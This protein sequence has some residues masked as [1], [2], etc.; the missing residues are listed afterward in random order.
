MEATRKLFVLISLTHIVLNLHPGLVSSNVTGERESM[1]NDSF[2]DNQS[3]EI[4]GNQPNSPK[5]YKV[6][7]QNGKGIKQLKMLTKDKDMMPV[8]KEGATF[9]DLKTSDD[10][11]SHRGGV[12]T[13]INDCHHH[14]GECGSRDD[15]IETSIYINLG[16]SS[17][18]K[19][20]FKCPPCLCT[21]THSNHIQAHCMGKHLK[22]I[23]STLPKNITYL[24]MSRNP[25]S[26]LNISEISEYTDLLSF[27]LNG[28][29]ALVQVSNDS[30]P[31]AGS[32]LQQL[33]LGRNKISEV[34]DTS[35]QFLSSLIYL[36]LSKNSLQRINN[37][38]FQGLVNLR[39]LDLSRNA[40]FHIDVGAFDCLTKLEQ[41]DL[42]HNTRFSYSIHHMPSR[43]FMPFQELRILYIQGNSNGFMQYPNAALATLKNLQKLVI[44]GLHSPANFGP[45][46]RSLRSFRALEFGTH[47]G[48]CYLVNITET[49]FE[50]IPYLN[51]LAL[52]KC[53]LKEVDRNFYKKIPHL[54]TLRIDNGE[55]TYTLFQA[56]E[57][58]EGLQNSSLKSLSFNRLY[59]T[60]LSC[61][62]LKAEQ[63]RYLQN[64]PLEELDLSFNYITFLQYDFNEKLP[65]SLKRLL[66]RNNAFGTKYA[67]LFGLLFLTELIELD[68][69]NQNVDQ[70][71]NKFIYYKSDM[72]HSCINQQD[73]KELK[74]YHSLHINDPNISSLAVRP[75]GNANVT[76]ST[77]KNTVKKQFGTMKGHLRLP[78]K[79]KII[80]ATRY[81]DFGLDL[82]ARRITTKHSLQ[83]IDLS[84]SFMAK[85]GYGHILN[86]IVKADL[87]QNYCK[88]I[89]SHFFR[90]NKSLRSLNL[91]NNFLGPS[92]AEDEN[93]IIFHQLKFVNSL[94]ISTN[95][96]YHL[97]DKFLTGLVQLVYIHLSDNKLRALTI[98]FANNRHIRFINAT[99][100]SISWIGRQT[101]DNLD[102]IARTHPVALDL[103][104]NPLPCTC[105]GLEILKWL[106]TTKV[107]IL[108][109]DFL[110]CTTRAAHAEDIGNL[111]LRINELQRQCRSTTLAVVL[112]SVIVAV[113]ITFIG[114]SLIYRYRW[115][116]IY[117]RNVALTRLFRNHNANEPCDFAYDA[118][119]VHTETAHNFVLGE[120]RQEL[121]R[122]R[123]HKLC[124]PEVDFMPGSLLVTDILAAAT[125]S[126][127]TVVICTPDIMQDNW[128]EYSI[129][130]ALNVEHFRK[131]KA[132]FLIL[133]EQETLQESHNQDQYRNQREEDPLLDHDCA[134]DKDLLLIK[135]RGDFIE[136]P[137]PGD[138]GVTEAVRKNFWD[139]ISEKLGHT[140][141]LNQP[142][143]VDD[144]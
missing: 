134:L 14:V 43:L 36:N 25:I 121:K 114:L 9:S 101:R 102:D 28:E 53:H 48:K 8:G 11:V 133:I 67:L 87:S 31:Q 10:K 94:D 4:Y 122:Q 128:A 77:P 55:T 40:I 27:E 63:A 17:F 127:T 66:L 51:Y 88:Y 12:K 34:E 90:F 136:Y 76:Y 24:D 123:G 91:S 96:I 46:L 5:A 137:L 125:N 18:K 132:L 64:I 100:N 80:R 74:K 104:Y 130:M 131:R 85:W 120:L 60:R 111:E 19:N 42:S 37:M 119:I 135:Q 22:S 35:F 50:N 15:G 117:L 108:N 138:H 116:L 62:V 58:L 69:S 126:M 39:T 75:H 13:P 20:D 6:M 68:V 45:E 83:E 23:P 82:F 21:V 52:E 129:K 118:F 84:N 44:D 140:S 70:R 89:H 112:I 29:P 38:T 3:G 49:I 41:L 57:D 47:G 79:L 98:S 7:S 107:S 93:G 99:K 95:L 2:G 71:Y 144:Q 113:L 81:T 26:Y 73:S 61:V 142:A 106:S 124:I 78:P 56:F 65:R 109:K 103:T 54:S 86:T 105:E 141:N 92:F 97:P 33:D 143:Y 115:R 110:K 1:Q 59:Q 139:R 30:V 16:M 72:G 32:N